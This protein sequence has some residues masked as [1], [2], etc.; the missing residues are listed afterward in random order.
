MLS[1]SLNKTFLSLFYFHN[2]YYYY[3]YYY[4]CYYYCCCCCSYYY[5]YYYCF[6]FISTEGFYGRMAR[7]PSNYPSRKMVFLAL[8]VFSGC[9][10]LAISYSRF[11]NVRDYV[12]VTK[13]GLV[14]FFV[15][16]ENA[17]ARN[18][19]TAVTTSPPTKKSPLNKSS[20][21]LQKRSTPCP[22]KPPHHGNGRRH[23]S[24]SFFFSFFFF[25]FLPPF[26]IV[27]F[28][29]CSKKIKK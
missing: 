24:S 25:F 9:T 7:M 10:V 2:Y 4:Y 5:Y 22:E 16:Y 13:Q 29:Q 12:A 18:G 8:I 3:Y 21:S 1:A 28:R 15:A 11:V 14:S 27:I 26:I 19:S 17:S 23:S 20:P 6:S